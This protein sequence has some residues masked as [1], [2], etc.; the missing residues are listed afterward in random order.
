MDGGTKVA[1]SSQ[2]SKQLA[3]KHATCRLERKQQLTIDLKKLQDKLVDESKQQYNLT[4]ENEELKDQMKEARNKFQERL[5]RLNK[6]QPREIAKDWSKKGR[7]PNW[8]V[9]LVLEMLIKHTPPSCI[10]ANII[11]AVAAIHSDREDVIRELPSVSFMHDLQDFTFYLL[12]PELFYP[13][14]QENIQS[15]DMTQEIG[16]EMAGVMALDMEDE[17]KATKDYI[18]YGVNSM[19]NTTQEDRQANMGHHIMVVIVSLR[20]AMLTQLLILIS[21]LRGYE[22]GSIYNYYPRLIESLI[23]IT[24]EKVKDYR[25]HFNEAVERQSEAWRLKDELAL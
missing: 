19:K 18:F 17:L 2:K 14:R 24:Q 25:L 12:L 15:T 3:H 8:V 21:S 1:Q 22:H 5:D 4:L 20:H 11:S 16:A 23:L 13:S 10:A 9:Q 6:Y 7:W